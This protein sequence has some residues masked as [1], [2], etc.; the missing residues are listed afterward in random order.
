MGSIDIYHSTTA[1]AYTTESMKFLEAVAAK[2]ARRESLDRVCFVFPNRR[3]SVFFRK[4][5]GQQAGKPLFVPALLTIDGLFQQLSGLKPVGRVQ[6][7]DILYRIYARLLEDEGRQAEPF[8]DF[9]YWG[10]VILS[11]FDDIDKYRV[12]AGRML[13]NLR[14]LKALSSDYDFLN[15]RQKAAIAEFCNSFFAGMPGQ[16]R[17]DESGQ[18]RHDGVRGGFAALWNILLPLYDSFRNTLLQE[19]L[20]YPGMIYRSVVDSI[21]PDTVLLPRYDEV[22]FIGLNALNACE[23]ALLTEL[24]KEGKADFFWDFEGPMLHDRFNKAGLFIRDNLARFPSRTPLSDITQSGL[25]AVEVI[26]VPS[27]VGQTRKVMQILEDLN[28]EG[29]LKEAEETAVVLPDETL[30]FPMLGAI[31]SCI[32][33]V[34]VTMG[35]PMSAGQA[36]SLVS[37]LERLQGNRRTKSGDTGFYHRDVLDL[38]DHPYIAAADEAGV[39]KEMLSEIRSRNRIFVDADWLASF[40]PLFAELFVPVEKTSQLN[41]YVQ[42]VINRLQAFQTPLEREFLCRCSQLAADLASVPLDFDRLEARTWFRL[43]H[44]LAASETVPFEG[45]P[46]SGL[47]LMGP[48]ETRALDFKNIIMLSVG[49]GKF[50]SR[51]VSSSFIPYNLRLGFGLPTYELQDAIWAYYFYRSISRAERVY[52]LYDSRTEGLQS[53]EESRYIKQLKYHYDLPVTEK[54]ATYSLSDT[55]AQ[56]PVRTVEKTPQVMQELED[57]FIKGDGVFSAS[58]LNAYVDCPLKFY[59]QYVRRIKERDEVV[60]EVDSSRFGTIYHSVMQAVYTPFTGKT[61]NRTD[62]ERIRADKAGLSRLVAGAFADEGIEEPEGED[63]ILVNLVLRFVDRTLELDSGMTPFRFLGAEVRKSAPLV[64]P[65]GRKVSLSGYIDR[66]DANTPDAV[67][68]VDY[69]T[70]TVEKKDDCRYVERLFDRTLATRPYIAFQLYFY[71]LL[72]ELQPD[73]P[74]GVRYEPCVYALR[75]FFAQAPASHTLAPE[76]VDEYARRLGELIA[77]IFDPQTPFAG[78]CPNDRICG[79]CNFRKVCNR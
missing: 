70:G 62:I 38:L 68:V 21:A 26:R 14:E 46:L 51:T 25:P 79:Y 22:V 78:D 27:S 11:D 49:E 1:K 9:I 69:K 53:G 72:M 47:Q 34:N 44:R 55:A 29:R 13:V 60:E 18:A 7:L 30:L 15:D 50:P 24:Q 48:L 28:A 58:S 10:D 73:A 42:A 67:R 54:V 40:G 37:I 71:A 32:G 39:V 45:E 64:L 8:D 61:V 65:D 19:K 59:Y 31:P 77:S 17:H 20:G 12:D 4:Y 66:L 35:Y 16:A 57:L 6:A 3:S 33:R 56:N 41:D 76:A 63:R 2:Y 36:D 74:K 43:L 23:T 75:D 52:L 5:L